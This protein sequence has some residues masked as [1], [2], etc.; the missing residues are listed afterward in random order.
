MNAGVNNQMLW[1]YMS[2]VLLALA[3]MM[4]ACDKGKNEVPQGEYKEFEGLDSQND[5]RIETLKS[6]LFDEPQNFQLI[7]A[8][9]DAYFEAGRYVQAIDI[10]NKALAVN[11]SDPDCLND[12]AL[13]YFY[14]GNTDKAIESVNK[15]TTA[16]PAYTH[17]WLTKGFILLSVG[18]QE[19]AVA[20]L[21]KVKE[22]DMGGGLSME[23]DSF[24][25]Q[26]EQMKGQ[27]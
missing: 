26:I 19:E 18:R 1:R 4:P 13:S 6:R 23:A 8:L 3:L 14:T 20:P 17:A 25:G 16:D 9:G 15:A 7:A 12:L 22:L 2:L 10:Y 11:S 21:M 24:L 27:K 5:Q